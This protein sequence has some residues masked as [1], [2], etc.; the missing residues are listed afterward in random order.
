MNAGEKTKVCFYKKRSSVACKIKVPGNTLKYRTG[1]GKSIRANNGPDFKEYPLIIHFKT[2]NSLLDLNNIK[3]EDIFIDPASLDV[4]YGYNHNS[5]RPH[6]SAK[7]T[8]G[9]INNW[10]NHGC[11]D[12]TKFHVNKDRERNLWGQRPLVFVNP[13]VSCRC[14]AVNTAVKTGDTITVNI[15]DTITEEEMSLLTKNRENHTIY[16]TM[17]CASKAR[18]VTNEEVQ[19]MENFIENY[20]ARIQKVID[21]NNLAIVMH[22]SDMF[23]EIGKERSFGYDLGSLWINTKNKEYNRY[24]SILKYAKNGSVLSQDMDLKFPYSTQS[25][26]VMKKQFEKVQEV[27]LAETG[28]TLYCIPYLD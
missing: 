11:P 17:L 21:A 18:N 9:F 14:N 8:R 27:V 5:E 4:F 3:E 20:N 28:E 26:T 16:G 22:I 6:Y 10:W 25:I 13:L 19:E 24:K 1:M 23:D 7:L 15:G 2:L 12:L